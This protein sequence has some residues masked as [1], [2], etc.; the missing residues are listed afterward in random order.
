MIVT[1]R[2][3]SVNLKRPIVP[4]IVVSKTSSKVKN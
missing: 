2:K 3:H 1:R 4:V